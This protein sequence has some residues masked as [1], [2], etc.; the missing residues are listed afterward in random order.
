MTFGE[1]VNWVQIA[2][3]RELTRGKPVITSA[4]GAS[5]G[6]GASSIYFIKPEDPILTGAI[7][8]GH[9][10]QSTNLE[11][12]PY[13]NE[14]E[15]FEVIMKKGISKG[16]FAD[17]ALTAEKYFT[18]ENGVPSYRSRDVVRIREDGTISYAGRS[19]DL[20]KINNRIVEPAE[21]NAVLRQIPGIRYSVVLPH[22]RANGRFYL[23]GHIALELGSNLQPSDIYERLLAVL[24]SHL[25]PAMLVKHEDIPLLATGKVDRQHLQNQEWQRW[26][27]ED[28]KAVH[29]DFE[30]FALAKLRLVLGVPD[31]Q[32]NEDLFGAGLDSLLALEFAQIADEYGF[33][34]VTPSTFLKH[35]NAKSMGEYLQSS[36]D[37]P[38]SN[39]V[40][41]NETGSKTPIFAFPGAG[42]T[43]LSYLD[44]ARQLG[45]D[46]PV[47]VIEPLGLH[48]GE[49]FEASIDEMAAN[50]LA[51]ILESAPDGTIKLM[52]Y[53]GGGFVAIATAILLR[54][55]NR[56]VQVAILDSY[57]IADE[58]SLS[59]PMF[60]L[61]NLA[62]NLRRLQRRLQKGLSGRGFGPGQD[63]IQNL[64]NVPSS[65][66]NNYNRFKLHL[67]QL[68]VKYRFSEKPTFAVHLL[69]CDEYSQKFVKQWMRNPH[70]TFEK[71]NGNHNTLM[72]VENIPDLAGK[73]TR[74]F[75]E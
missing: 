27:D 19:D 3:I 9:T 7:P 21:A 1:A 33:T 55:Q 13:G 8:V 17:E 38:D 45:A 11:F 36:Q 22:R 12:V 40:V 16:Y 68:I 46:Q 67:A 47:M 41:I 48:V 63:S 24:S 74:F 29:T 50:A 26:R 44:L 61:T 20:V 4:Y 43:A 30:R 42:D 69:Y 52:G 14:P 62:R 57:R 32:M 54:K 65:Q 64:R 5:E 71:I 18:D 70:L 25:V 58:I 73:I 35:R 6:P 2:R 49:S 66:L 56:L 23:I 39:L 60:E 15:L 34:K 10:S 28:S 53:S 72:D 51:Q 37:Q 31:L 75:S 59:K